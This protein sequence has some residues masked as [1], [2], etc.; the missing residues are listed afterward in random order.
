MFPS[1]S[2]FFVTSEDCEGKSQSYLTKPRLW[3]DCQY[4]A[5][6]RID[7]IGPDRRGL[8]YLHGTWF[9]NGYFASSGFVDYHM[10]VRSYLV[11]PLTA[12]EAVG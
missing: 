8:F 4:L 11:T 9:L 5:E 6:L 7:S 2:S 3:Y 12:I 1:E 10:G